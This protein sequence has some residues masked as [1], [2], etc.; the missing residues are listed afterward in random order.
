[1]AD[2]KYTTTTEMRER[3]AWTICIWTNGMTPAAWELASPTEKAPYYKTAHEVLTAMR[4]PTAE[5]VSTG[6]KRLLLGYN[7]SAGGPPKPPKEVW[8]D[9]IDAALGRYNH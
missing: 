9:M 7:I 6:L 4:E 3:I 2:F 1:M 5:M 8:S